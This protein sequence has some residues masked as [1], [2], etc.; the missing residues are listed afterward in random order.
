MLA[1]MTASEDGMDGAQDATQDGAVRDLDAL[2][3][4][5][6]AALPSAV[7]KVADRLTEPYRAFIAASPF[8]VM[9]TVGPDGLDVSPRGDPPGFAVAEDA[10]TL[11]IPDRP[12]NNRLD[13]MRNLLADPR[14]ALLFLIPGVGE[15]LRV[16]GRAEIRADRALRDRFTMAGGAPATVLRVRVERVYYHCQKAIARSRL[17]DPA[18][19]APRGSVPSMGRMLAAAAPGPVDADAAEAAYRERQK[20]LY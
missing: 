2:E 12:G 10:R 15:T 11:L 14:I 6:G 7:D 13:G 19:Q 17:W 16:M 3:A 8:L 1:E 5:Y 9:A 4:L 20:R 18:A